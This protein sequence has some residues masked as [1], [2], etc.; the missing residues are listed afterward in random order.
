MDADDLIFYSEGES[1]Y[2]GGF[3]VNSVLL[4]NG[5]SPL[6]TVNNGQNGGGNNVSDLFKDLAIPSGL[7]YLPTKMNGGN[8]DHNTD[9]KDS[10]MGEEDSDDYVSEDIHD[11]LLS[12]V[13]V[14]NNNKNKNKNSRKKKQKN[15]NKNT[16]R[17]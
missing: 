1:I 9:D 17:I 6:Y 12:L 4:K 11:K 2:S 14:D 3:K 10:D 5:M 8:F 16:K 7:L 13:S 15:S